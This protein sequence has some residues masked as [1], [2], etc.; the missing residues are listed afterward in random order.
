MKYD[1]IDEGS[2]RV[3]YCVVWVFS[4]VCPS[5]WFSTWGGVFLSCVSSEVVFHVGGGVCGR[6]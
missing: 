5:R 6:G 4:F 2:W 1:M 3:V